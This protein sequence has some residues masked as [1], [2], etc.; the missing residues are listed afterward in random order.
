MSHYRLVC[1]EC[2]GTITQCRCF[3]PAKQTRVACEPC[4]RCKE[5]AQ[6]ARVYREQST[7]A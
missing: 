4:E 5:Q 6:P 3:D 7:E 1:P 2:R